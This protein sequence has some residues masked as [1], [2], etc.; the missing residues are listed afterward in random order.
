MPVTV[1]HHTC[2]R[3]VPHAVATRLRFSCCR[4]L[5]YTAAGSCAPHLRTVIAMRINVAFH[6]S[7]LPDVKHTPRPQRVATTF[8]FIFF[9]ALA[10]D[11]ARTAFTT[12]R[13]MLL[14]CTA[15]H[16]YAAHLWRVP[17]G[18]YT[19]PARADAATLSRPVPPDIEQG[20]YRTGRCVLDGRCIAA[21]R[22]LPVCMTP[23]PAS[24]LPILALAC[25][26]IVALCRIQHSTL[27]VQL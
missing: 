24:R 20:V 2:A 17:G 3:C 21:H 12:L 9:V 22:P 15:P 25:C 19:H 13:R 18:T 26:Y 14:A 10:F 6:A 23:V 27:P 5:V 1:R 8:G 11:R 4:H 7:R 16:L